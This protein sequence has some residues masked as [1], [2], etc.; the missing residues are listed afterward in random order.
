LVVIELCQDLVDELVL[1]PEAEVNEGLFE[2]LRV[3]HAAAV[4]V[5]DVEGQ[6]DVLDLLEG[7]CERDVVFGI[8]AFLLRLFWLL[9]GGR[10]WDCFYGRRWAL[11]AH[12][13]IAVNYYIQN[14]N[15]LQINGQTYL[16][17]L[18]LLWIMRIFQ[19]DLRYCVYI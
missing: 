8:E 6:F 13:N 9:F 11:L 2:L 3:D 10:S 17:L 18:T 5:E 12:S 14:R 1:S 4:A 7:N 15:R 16:T 19:K